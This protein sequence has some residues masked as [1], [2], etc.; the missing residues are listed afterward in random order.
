MATYYAWSTF[1]K[2]VNEWGRVEGYIN[3]GDE[4]TQSELGVDDEEWQE[5][6]DVGAI[7]DEEYPDAPEGV[8][9][10]EYLAANPAPTEVR[11]LTLP[12]TPQTSET[13]TVEKENTTT[14][15]TTDTPPWQQ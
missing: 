14:T 8:S 13:K 6:L 9:P 4:V 7:R 10:A 15:T 11:E 12:S 5:L 3:P 2:G 1:K